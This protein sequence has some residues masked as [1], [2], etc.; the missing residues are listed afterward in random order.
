[1]DSPLIAV[2]ILGTGHRGNAR[3][4]IPQPRRIPWLARCLAW[5]SRAGASA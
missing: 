1:M 3:R 4:A 2:A 5:L